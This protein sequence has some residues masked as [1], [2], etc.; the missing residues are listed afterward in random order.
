M[1]KGTHAFTKE[2]IINNNGDLKGYRMNY[3]NFDDEIK[4]QKFDNGY[5]TNQ[6][7]TN[8]G[9]NVG[10]NISKK[11]KKKVRFDDNVYEYK[12]NEYNLNPPTAPV[13][14]FELPYVQHLRRKTRNNNLIKK[15]E[16]NNNN[17]KTK[18]KRQA[19]RKAKAKAKT[20]GFFDSLF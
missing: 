16:L 6:I 14:S 8:I 15:L 18:T 4:I 12:L 2:M 19:K 20:K 9:N 11:N 7:I 10:K 1:H 13:D 5:Q 3:N 17:N